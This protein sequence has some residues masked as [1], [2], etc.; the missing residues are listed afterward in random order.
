M[1]V[2]QAEF[3]CSASGLASLPT[4]GKPEFAVIGRSN[5]GKSSLINLLTGRKQLAITS[6]KPGKTQ[7]INY[8]HINRSWYLVDLPGYGYARVSKDKKASF[9]KLIETYLIKSEDLHCLFILLDSR[10]KPQAIDLDFIEWAGRRE[11]PIALVFTKADKL[12][13][14][15]LAQTLNLFEAVLLKQWESL[16]PVFTTSAVR[17]SG[18]EEMLEF[19]ADAMNNPD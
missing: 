18:M 2:Q 15:Q 19:I 9:T 11:I 8:Y 14:S 3:I 1:T 16:P 12:T 13:K 5:V 7:T 4:T 10:L 6:A 17:G